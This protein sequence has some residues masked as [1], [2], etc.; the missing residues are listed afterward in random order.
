VSALG[1]QKS[2]PTT[3]ESTEVGRYLVVAGTVMANGQ[4]DHTIIRIDTATGRAWRFVWVPSTLESN[5]SWTAYWVEIPE[6]T[7]ATPVPKPIQ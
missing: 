3:K 4:P 1:A 2:P 7:K 5:A 6:W